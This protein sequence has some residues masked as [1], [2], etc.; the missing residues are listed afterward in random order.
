MRILQ[1]LIAATDNI[2]RLR[3][4]HPNWPLWVLLLASIAAAFFGVPLEQGFDATQ[5]VPLSPIF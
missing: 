2:A 4:S 5:F 1:A 3:K